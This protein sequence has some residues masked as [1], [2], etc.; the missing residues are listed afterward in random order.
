MHEKIHYT[1]YIAIACLPK[2][3]QIEKLTSHFLDDNPRIHDINLSELHGCATNTN[4]PTIATANVS[5]DFKSECHFP[6]F[7]NFTTPISIVFIRKNTC[8]FLNFHHTEMFFDTFGFPNLLPIHLSSHISDGKHST[9]YLSNRSMYY[10]KGFIGLRFPNSLSP[11]G[12]T[13]VCR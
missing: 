7:A 8:N 13:S 2:C 6:F 4:P 9:P 12:E 5:S 11:R 3:E 1:F 10:H